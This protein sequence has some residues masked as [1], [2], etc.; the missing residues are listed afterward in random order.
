MSIPDYCCD[1]QEEAAAQAA[2]SATKMGRIPI[3]EDIPP[4]KIFKLA[5]RCGATASDL[6]GAY[7]YTQS[8]A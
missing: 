3:E 8:P 7:E 2:L 4:G 5:L 6:Y 1:T